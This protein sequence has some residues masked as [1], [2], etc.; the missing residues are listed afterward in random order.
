MLYNLFDASALSLELGRLAHTVT[1]LNA[2]PE[3]ASSIPARYHT[4]VEIDREIVSTAILLPSVDS[5]R[6]QAEVY[7]QS[8]G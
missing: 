2:D 1:C 5:R 8:T 3:A 4:F 6:V 7:A